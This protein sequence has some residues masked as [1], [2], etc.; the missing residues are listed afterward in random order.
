MFTSVSVRSA[1]AYRQFSVE[2]DVAQADPH[3]LV[4]LLFDGL[5]SNVG[6]ARAALARGDIK[7][8]C[9]HVVTAVRILEE[10]LKASLNMEQG[11]VL[12]ANLQGVY[13]YA[14]LRLTQANARNEDALLQEVIQVIAPISDGWRQISD[15]S[16]GEQPLM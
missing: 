15:E 11:G 10:G 1:N 4:Q 13:D 3:K 16:A 12:A 5:L 6:A 7:A 2:A 14:V 9:K 8:K